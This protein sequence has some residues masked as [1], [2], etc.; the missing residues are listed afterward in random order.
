MLPLVWLCVPAIFALLFSVAD[1]PHALKSLFP[2]T[3]SSSPIF[4]TLDRGS[5]VDVPPPPSPP[6]PVALLAILAGFHL[7]LFY[8]ASL[9]YRHLRVFSALLTTSLGLVLINS[10]LAGWAATAEFVTAVVLKLKDGILLQLD[11]YPLSITGL[12]VLPQIPGIVFRLLATFTFGFLALDF[13]SIFIRSDFRITAAVARAE[14]LKSY[15]LLLLEESA[16]L[17]IKTPDCSIMCAVSDRAATFAGYSAQDCFVLNLVLVV[18]TSLL[19]LL[20]KYNRAS[21][22]YR[23][24][25]RSIRRSLGFLKTEL[26]GIGTR[27]HGPAVACLPWLSAIAIWIFRVGYMWACL[28]VPALVSMWSLGREKAV[29]NVRGLARRRD[30]TDMQEGVAGYGSNDSDA[31]LLVSASDARNGPDTAGTPADPNLSA[32][33]SFASEI[34]ADMSASESDGSF[35][36]MDGE[37]AQ[38]LVVVEP[39]AMERFGMPLPLLL[40]AVIGKDESNDEFG[41]DVFVMQGVAGKRTHTRG[42]SVDT[43]KEQDLPGR[44]SP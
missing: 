29:E 24:L 20:L 43:A 44:W 40:P 26:G 34:G 7:L 25:F 22:S 42:A 16:R 17:C 28:R 12:A 14:T 41:P 35:V 6:S 30:E 11:A 31:V 4:R 33:L 39:V 1:A 37:D 32:A 27:Y 19:I 3:I 10:G 8:L 5:T 2:S 9:A 21:I 13:I 23:R 18:A 38:L 15:A 36:S